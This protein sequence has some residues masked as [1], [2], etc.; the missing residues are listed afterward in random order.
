MTALVGVS[1]SGKSTI[2]ALLQVRGGLFEFIC[3]D[4]CIEFSNIWFLKLFS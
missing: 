2:A 3:L 1:G 4:A